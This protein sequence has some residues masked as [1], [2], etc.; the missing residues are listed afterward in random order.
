M[1]ATIFLA[2][3]SSRPALW[4][5]QA[6][7]QCDLGADA[8]APARSAHALVLLPVTSG[9]LEAGDEHRLGG[10][11]GGLEVLQGTNRVEV[12][13]LGQTGHDA[14]RVQRDP[15]ER[16]LQRGGD[17]HQVHPLGA[18][19][20]HLQLSQLGELLGGG[21]GTGEQLLEVAHGLQ[22]RHLCLVLG[23]DHSTSAT[24]L[25]D[26]HPDHLPRCTDPP[27]GLF[28]P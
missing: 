10:G 19:G 22:P 14:G 17:A 23:R 2:R 25:D 8:L 24:V 21:A 1:P 20:S 18:Q 7:G 5:G 12:L 9:P 15:G 16:L 11:G 27:S 13:G 6:P 26:G 3:A 28:S 4:G